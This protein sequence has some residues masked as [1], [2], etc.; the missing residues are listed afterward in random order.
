MN[1]HEFI[2]TV[3]MQLGIMDTKWLHA[4]YSH[5][6]NIHGALSPIPYNVDIPYLLNKYEAD[7]E[8]WGI[9]YEFWVKKSQERN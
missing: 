6:A 8:K 4:A 3:E 9:P 2:H 7:G 1:I 5:Y